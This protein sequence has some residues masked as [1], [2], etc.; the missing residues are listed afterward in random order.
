[1]PALNYSSG[2]S[3]VSNQ[4]RRNSSAGRMLLSHLKTKMDGSVKQV[5]RVKKNKKKLK[6]VSKF[7]QLE[8]S[9]EQG[10]LKN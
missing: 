6:A 2:A 9:A 1:M 5:I 8:H 10:I 3:S 4:K 7:I